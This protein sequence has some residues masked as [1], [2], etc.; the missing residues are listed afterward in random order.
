MRCSMIFLRRL[1][2]RRRKDDVGVLHENANNSGREAG[3]VRGF[4]KRSEGEDPSGLHRENVFLSCILF[5]PL[6]PSV[7]HN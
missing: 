7:I 5:Y 3:G 6:T 2:C 4:S 1:S